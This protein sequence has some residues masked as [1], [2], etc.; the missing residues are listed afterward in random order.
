MTEIA[1][2]GTGGARERWSREASHGGARERQ[3]EG[4]ASRKGKEYRMKDGQY[5]C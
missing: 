4:T 5:I 3:R 2:G 1:G